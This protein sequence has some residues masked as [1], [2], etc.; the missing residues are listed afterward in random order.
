[1]IDPLVRDLVEHC[2]AAP[3]PLRE[4]LEFW[5]TSCPRLTIFEDAIDQGLL[6]RATIAGMTFLQPTAA[7]RAIIGP[8]PAQTG[9]M[10]TGQRVPPNALG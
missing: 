5:R 1:M 7:G 9:L 6:E 2:A 10:R 8:A 4:I 3:R